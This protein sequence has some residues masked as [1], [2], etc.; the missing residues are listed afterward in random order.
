MAHATTRLWT[1]YLVRHAIAAE[2]GDAWPDDE[3]RPLTP[4]GVRRMAR[5]VEGLAALDVRVELVVTSP[6]VRARQTAELVAA[7]VRGAD[8]RTTPAVVVRPE[9]APDGSPVAVMTALAAQTTASTFALVGHEP[10]LGALAAWLVGA[11]RPIPFRKGAVCRIDGRG[12]PARRGSADLVW[13][14]TPKM[15][16]RLGR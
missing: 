7:G 5:G 12:W 10:D 6:L 11:A 2:R 8:G 14:A 1:C 3:L 16:R 15:L 4:D 13:F 9:L